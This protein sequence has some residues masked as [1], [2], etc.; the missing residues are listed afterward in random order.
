V[1]RFNALVW[2]VVAFFVGPLTAHAFVG[3]MSAGGF[4]WQFAVFG[5]FW[6]AGAIVNDAYNG[7]YRLLVNGSTYEPPTGP[8]MT[9]GGRQL[10]YPVQSMSG[11]DVS[12]IVYVPEADF[13][14]AR[15]LDLFSNPGDTDVTLNVSIET[16]LSSGF[17]TTVTASSSGDTAVG[18]DDRWFTTGGGV[19]SLGHVI[20]GNEAMV[21]PGSASHSFGTA[22]VVYSLTIPAGARVALLHFGIRKATAEE[23]QTEAMRIL[24][25]PDDTLNGID[26]YLDEVVNFSLFTAE[27]PRVRFE[28]PTGLVEGDAFDVVATVEDLEGDTVTFS[29]DL[30]DDG[31]FGEM[32]G[33]YTYSVPAG[34]TDG[35]G[36]IRIAIEAVD[37]ADHTAVRRRRVNVANVAPMITSTPPGMT[38]NGAT[39]RYELAVTDPGGAADPLAYEMVSG[40]TGM[41]VSPEGVVQWF[42]GESDITPADE[43]LEIV[44]EVSDD[45]GGTTTQEWTLAVSAN[46]PPAAP[47]PQYPTGGI[48]IDDLMPRLVAEDAT[49][50]D[51]DTLMYFYQLDTVNTF[52]SANLRESGPISEGAAFTAWPQS[53]PLTGGQTYFWRVWVS[54]G[55]VES[56]RREATFSVVGGDAGP[57]DASAGSPDAGPGL[58]LEDPDDGCG[59]RTGSATTAVV[60]AIPLLVLFYRRRR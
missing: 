56:E 30:D 14:Y 23:V 19:A 46:R 53:T 26:D 51:L 57:A 4:N 31:T 47:T 8:V 41:I 38:Y 2:L 21:R 7:G 27:A 37:S 52:D 25:V 5:D 49:D 44:V 28:V 11:V 18:A 10:E 36:G 29:W 3:L 43:P 54:D 15:Y 17:A 59:C 35:P 45:D 16:R 60:W 40:P 6:G 58:M 9:E 24:E 50:P 55:A 48:V 20:Q 22:S 34:A 42:P 12:R 1:R 33:V 39:F 13:D 32:P